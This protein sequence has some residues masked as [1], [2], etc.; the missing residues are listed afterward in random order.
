[1]LFSGCEPTCKETVGAA[2]KSPARGKGRCGE[3]RLVPPPFGILGM[4]VY[5]YT[6]RVHLSTGDLLLRF[7]DPRGILEITRCASGV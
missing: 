3:I 6:V 2:I 7:R 1:M 5:G 4:W